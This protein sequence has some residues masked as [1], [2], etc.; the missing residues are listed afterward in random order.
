MDEVAFPHNVYIR[1][2]STVTVNG[3]YVLITKRVVVFVRRNFATVQARS[4]EIKLVY[5][6]LFSISE[7]YLWKEYI[8]ADLQ[9]M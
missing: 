5:C 1:V 9:I 2:G 6:K 8:S 4:Q 7:D 3:I